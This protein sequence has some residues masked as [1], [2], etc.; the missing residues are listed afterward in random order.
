MSDPYELH[1]NSLTSPAIDG[2][3]I[4]PNDGADLQ[5]FTRGIYVGGTGDI[6]LV[7]AKGS[8][9]TFVNVQGGTLLP[10]RARRVMATGTDAT[11]LV[12]LY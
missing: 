5:D 4:T 10:F 12:G 8:T 1:P 3:A 6:T 9:V 7:L 11:N 2:F